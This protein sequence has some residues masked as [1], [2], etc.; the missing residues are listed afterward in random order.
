MAKILGYEE[1]SEPGGL[2]A[3]YRVFREP[4]EDDARNRV[5]EHPVPM[6]ASYSTPG[7]GD[8]TMISEATEVE[9]FVFVLKPENDPHARTALAAYAW[10]VKDQDPALWGDLM[11][12]LA[13][14]VDD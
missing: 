9:G 10:A 1:D 14:W 11:N 2:Y 5:G 3:K 6:V 12:V 8:F 13:E 7:D 4:Q